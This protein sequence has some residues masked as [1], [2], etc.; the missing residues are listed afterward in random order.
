MKSHLS[1][2]LIQIMSI[3]SRYETPSLIWN[4]PKQGLQTPSNPIAKQRSPVIAHLLPTE[5]SCSCC[6][7]SVTPC[8]SDPNNGTLLFACALM[9]IEMSPPHERP[10]LFLGAQRQH[11]LQSWLAVATSDSGVVQPWCGWDRHTRISRS[12]GDREAQLVISFRL[13]GSAAKASRPLKIYFPS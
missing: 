13:I 6:H 1:C 10:A 2:L 12:F 11:L 8:E 3:H 5:V 9:C 4:P 7:N